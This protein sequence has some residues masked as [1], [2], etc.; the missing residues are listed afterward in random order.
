MH[1]II[2]KEDFDRKYVEYQGNII[3]ISAITNE[4]RLKSKKLSLGNINLLKKKELIVYLRLFLMVFYKGK[5][6][7]NL[8]ITIP[9]SLDYEL[10]VLQFYVGLLDY[11]INE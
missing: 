11:L 8:L 10:F 9:F 7:K 5:E 4:F 6:N 2:E 3:P 1:K